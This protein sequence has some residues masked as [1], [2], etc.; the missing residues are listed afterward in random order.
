MLRLPGPR[1]IVEG[2]EASVVLV[3]HFG[4]VSLDC[5]QETLQAAGLGADVAVECGGRRYRAQ[6]GPTFASVSP[7][8]L[9]VI[10]DSYGQIAVCARDGSAAEVMSVCS[11]DVVRI[12]RDG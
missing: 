10:V 2:L 11:G 4:N 9:V 5:T 1:H 7:G 12:Q 3:D 6:V 8:A